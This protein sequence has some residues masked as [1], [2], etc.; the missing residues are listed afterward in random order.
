ME[1][2]CD[3]D[4]S[5]SEFLARRLSFRLL[6]AL[7]FFWDVVVRVVSCDELLRWGGEWWAYYDSTTRNYY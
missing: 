1:K 5:R 2:N 6:A 4:S 3:A 7:L